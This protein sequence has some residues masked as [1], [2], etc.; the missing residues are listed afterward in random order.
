MPWKRKRI[1]SPKGRLLF[2]ALAAAA[3]CGVLS[4][5]LG[6]LLH[7]RGSAL[8]AKYSAYRSLLGNYSQSE[9]KAAMEKRGGG[10]R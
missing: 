5:V 1:N 2:L 9:I 8:A 4:C 6:S 7:Q 3:A 10:T